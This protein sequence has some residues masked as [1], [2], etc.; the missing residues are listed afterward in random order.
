MPDKALTEFSI[1]N[2]QKL[3]TLLAGS[4]LTV[5]CVCRVPLTEMHTCPWL[6]LRSLCIKCHTQVHPSSAGTTVCLIDVQGCDCAC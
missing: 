3:D 2:N 6:V 5:S 1:S 4:P